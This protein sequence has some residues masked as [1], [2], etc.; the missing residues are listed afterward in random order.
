M[1]KVLIGSVWHGISVPNDVYKGPR[2]SFQ[3]DSSLARDSMP[4]GVNGSVW[5]GNP[6][7]T[8]LARD[9][10]PNGLHVFVWHGVSVPNRFGTEFRAKLKFMRLARR[11]RAKRSKQMACTFSMGKEQGAEQ[12]AESRAESRERSSQH[13][14]ES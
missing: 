13:R 14:A 10:V 5:H 12:R 6:C 7:Q 8:G 1:S 2:S 11:F 9:S 4:K 3:D